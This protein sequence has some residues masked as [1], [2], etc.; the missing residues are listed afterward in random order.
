MAHQF[1]DNNF[2]P[3]FVD[4]SVVQSVKDCLDV[5]KLIIHPVADGFFSCQTALRE[6]E[7]VQTQAADRLVLQ[8]YTNQ[9]LGPL[10]NVA[11]FSLIEASD[12]KEP[13]NFQ[14]L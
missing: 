10:I 12:P 8:Q 14:M 6:G 13:S 3:L 1:N 11:V 7:D 4:E 2:L 9:L 5:H